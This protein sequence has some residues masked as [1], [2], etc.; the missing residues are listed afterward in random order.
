V[1]E[2]TMTRFK[3]FAV[4][5]LA[6]AALAVGGLAAPPT[7]SAAPKTCTEALALADVYIGIGDM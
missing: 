3:A 6:A 1:R 7:A 2:N 4:A 5:A